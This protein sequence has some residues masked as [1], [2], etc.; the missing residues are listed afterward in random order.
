[1]LT[2]GVSP[3]RVDVTHAQGFTEVR[4]RRR[5]VFFRLV[6]FVL[7][8][9]GWA[10]GLFFG[11]ALLAAGTVEQPWFLPVWLT[12]WGLGGLFSLW[13]L[14]MNALVVESLIARLDRL[15]LLRRILVLRFPVE[16]PAAEIQDI[17]WVA[18]D[19]ARRVRHNGRR[20]PQTCLEI[21]SDSRNLRC[22]DGIGQAEAQAAII[23]IRQRLVTSRRRR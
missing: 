11:L 6:W 9:L 2:G 20:I 17:R 13:L 4:F 12:A 16:V 23:A 18:D 1:M 7:F 15:T 22:A 10:F 14:L 8:A 5:G 21:V 19:P 3:V